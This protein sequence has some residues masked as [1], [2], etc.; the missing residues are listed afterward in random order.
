MTAR[1]VASVCPTACGMCETTSL[2]L[3]FI[4][5]DRRRGER[6]PRVVCRFCFVMMIGIAPRQR[7]RV[8]ATDTV[9]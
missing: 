9:A 7:M 3:F 1:D 6:A 8:D 4:P 2:P 5:E